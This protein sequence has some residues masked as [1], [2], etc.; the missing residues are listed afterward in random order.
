MDLY[1]ISCQVSDWLNLA[2]DR[3]RRLALE[4]AAL[5]HSV[6]YRSGNFLTR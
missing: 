4:N 2:Q 3:D 1:E 6:P 5:N